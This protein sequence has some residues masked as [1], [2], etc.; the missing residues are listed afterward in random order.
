MSKYDDYFFRDS[1]SPKRIKKYMKHSYR[2]YIHVYE[3][4]M[5]N[6]TPNTWGLLHL[7]IG[8]IASFAPQFEPPV[9][10]MAVAIL[11]RYA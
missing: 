5:R 7:W 11:R 1:T 10:A 4:F 6:P 2:L 3:E 8:T 9:D